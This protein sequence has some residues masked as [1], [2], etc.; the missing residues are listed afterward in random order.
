MGLFIASLMGRQRYQRLF[1]SRFLP[2]N[3]VS[4]VEYDILMNFES[5]FQ[6][7]L[8]HPLDEIESWTLDF[9]SSIC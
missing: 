4:V 1:L 7:G 8:Y 9:L 2:S 3:L 5:I 6:T